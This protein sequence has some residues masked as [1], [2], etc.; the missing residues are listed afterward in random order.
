MAGFLSSVFISGQL[1]DRFGRRPI[2]LLGIAIFF[3]SALACTFST[4]YVMFTTLRYFV[5]FGASGAVTTAFVLLM[6]VIG[7][8]YR[9]VLGVSFQFGW[10]LGYV[11]LP[12][13]AWFV[14]EWSNLHLTLTVPWILLCSF[15]WLLPESPRW[16]ITHGKVEQVEKEIETALRINHKNVTDIGKIVKE[17]MY[18]E[19]R[20]EENKNRHATFF[21]LL[22]TPNMRKKT[23]NSFFAWFV[24]AFVY[25]GLSLSTNDLGG[26]PY[27]NFFVS[28]A[29]EFPSYAISIFVIKHLGRR[30]PLVVTMVLGGLACMLTI[31]IPDYLQWL[32]VTLAMFGK[33]CISASFGIVY[34]Y[35]AELFPT[36]VRNVGVGSS[37]MCARVGSMVAPFV[38]E[39][40][41]ATNNGVPLGIFGGLSV[42]SGIL[43]LLLPET[44]NMP[45]PDTLEE[46]EAFGKKPPS[47]ELESTK[48]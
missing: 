23:L 3:A 38:K 10:A 35:S 22:K 37:S 18:K 12:A 26:D 33:F 5:A 46:G 21:D 16:L 42:V 1:A 27:I 45:L 17:L 15:W 14:R 40:S 30:I 6:E 48:L 4:S 31:P 7:A 24:I 32:T 25:Y 20:E 9:T 39:L 44:N 11:L 47:M 36:V 34:V 43:I 13:L 41:K 28:G 29:V 8:Q 2:I 19:T